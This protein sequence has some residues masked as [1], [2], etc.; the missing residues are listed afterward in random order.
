M[1]TRIMLLIL[2]LLVTA[3]TGLSQRPSDIETKYGKPT[4]AYSVSELIWMTPEYAVDGQVCRMR[5]YPKRI[6]GN[7]N[8]YTVKELPF[9]DFKNVVDQLIPS[10][11]R[12]PKRQPFDGGWTTGGG[13]MWA[14]FTYETVRITY[15]A[16]GFSLAYDP[17]IL[18][19]GEFVFT[20]ADSDAKTAAKSNDDFLLFHTSKVEIVTIEWLQRKCA[21]Q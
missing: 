3:R 14:T 16:G 1:K 7:T 6:A 10:D 15:S 2:S 17:K 12:G 8:N 4:N 19:R 13:A 11:A 9:D 21:T 20:V 5:L 18:R